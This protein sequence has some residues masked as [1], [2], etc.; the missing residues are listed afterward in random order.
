MKLVHPSGPPGA[1]RQK[2]SLDM[3]MEECERESEKN[4]EK[5]TNESINIP[6]DDQ[7]NSTVTW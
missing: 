5:T 6:V 4:T 1:K 3:S 2:L 7:K